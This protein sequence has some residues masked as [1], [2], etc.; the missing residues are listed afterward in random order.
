[1]YNKMR[2]PAEHEKK[3][4]EDKQ[5]QNVARNTKKYGL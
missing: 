4:L 3:L 2:N 1:M 5:K